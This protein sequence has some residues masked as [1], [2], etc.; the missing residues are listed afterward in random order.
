MI[1]QRYTAPGVLKD[2]EH[3]PFTV[4]PDANDKPVVEV[5]YKEATAT[6]TPE[7]LSAMVLA[8]MKETAEA[9]LG[10]DVPI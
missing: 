1:G 4:K 7:Q 3:F 9:H 2:V 6:F 5:Q 10:H 8:K